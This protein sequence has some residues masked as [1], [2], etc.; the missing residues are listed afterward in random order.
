MNRAKLNLLAYPA[1]LA[2]MLLVANPVQAAEV[3]AQPTETVKSKPATPI[4]EVVF[5]QE[6]PE[7]A[8]QESSD[9]PTLTFGTV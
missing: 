8:M 4:F 2:S 5:E 6:T 7:S 3:V 9:A 1:L